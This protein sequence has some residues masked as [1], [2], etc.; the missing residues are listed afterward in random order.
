MKRYGSVIGIVDSKIDEYKSLHSSVWPEILDIIK[1]Y[2][3][4]NY[5][6]YLHRMPSGD[7][8]LFSYFEYYGLDIYS[9]FKNMGKEARMKDWWAICST[10]QVPLINRKS[11]E[12]W[13][14]M[15][16]VFHMD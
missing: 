2:H 9:D 6:I 12:W 3:I 7:C 13:A 10:F 15:L 16:E 5:T 14:E 11:G 8:Y 4:R 1:K